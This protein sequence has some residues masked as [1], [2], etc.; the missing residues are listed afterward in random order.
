MRPAPKIT[1]KY[2]VAIVEQARIEAAEE[3]AVRVP[4]P[5]AVAVLLAGLI[6]ISWLLV[7]RTSAQD[8]PA[9]TTPTP[10]ESPVLSPGKV[11]ILRAEEPRPEPLDQPDTLRGAPPSSPLPAKRDPFELSPATAPGLTVENDDPE[12][13]VQAFVTQNRK[14]AEGQLKSLKSEAE[15]LRARLQKVEAGIKRWESLV[16]A[17]DQSEGAA[18]DLA[19]PSDLHPVPRSRQFH[20][21]PVESN[22]LAPSPD[23]PPPGRRCVAR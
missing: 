8:T 2:V 15:R 20:P 19:G 14:V 22:R 13:S 17:L 18:Q 16:S 6:G 7:Q 5:L 10:A 11:P 23:G 1:P 3:A 21:K 4:P 9:T 12:K